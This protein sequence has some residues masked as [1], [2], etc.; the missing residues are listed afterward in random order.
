MEVAGFRLLVQLVRIFFSLETSQVSAADANTKRIIQ[1][2]LGSWCRH[3]L[4]R[5]ENSWKLLMCC[6]LIL[7]IKVSD[8]LVS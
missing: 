8:H 1:V 5:D 3:E 2:E 4:A 7:R 6:E